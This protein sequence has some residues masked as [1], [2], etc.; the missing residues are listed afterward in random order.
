MPPRALVVLAAVLASLAVA[1][2]TRAAASITS[3]AVASS[4]AADFRVLVTATKGP[5]GNAPSA[6]VN[7][8]AFR[9]VDGKWKSLG[10]RR[11]GDTNGFFWKVLT[12]PRSL[13]EF[14]ISANTPER[15]SLRLLV[16][17]AL[18]WSP[19]YRFRVASERLVAG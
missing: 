15:T 2:A 13:S 14:S 4:T 6:T 12:G 18:G 7:I 17:P 19:V 10:S 11:V 16:S 8:A 3:A 1:G 9:K 5:G